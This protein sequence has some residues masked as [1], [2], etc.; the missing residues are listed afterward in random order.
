MMRPV[1]VYFVKLSQSQGKDV[2]DLRVQPTYL[3]LTEK[4]EVLLALYRVLPTRRQTT[5]IV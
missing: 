1:C 5:C 3:I 4:P 2:H